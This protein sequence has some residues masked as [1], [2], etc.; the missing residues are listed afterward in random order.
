M[1][2]RG[3]PPDREE[4][5]SG[6]GPTAGQRWN[7]V[8]ARP[9]PHAPASA[10]VDGLF[11]REYPDDLEGGEFRTVPQMRNLIHFCDFSEPAVHYAVFSYDLATAAGQVVPVDCL[12][13]RGLVERGRPQLAPEDPLKESLLLEVV[14]ADGPLG[15]DIA[16]GAEEMADPRDVGT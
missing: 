12:F 7:Q 6:R 13:V 15:N 9:A 5:S 4:G 3:V 10:T 11:Y 14:L 2:C 16:G 8:Y 1:P